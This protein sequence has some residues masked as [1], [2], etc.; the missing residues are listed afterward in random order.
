MFTADLTDLNTDGLVNASNLSLHPGY[1]G[2][3][4]SR[5]IR[6]KGGKTLQDECKRILKQERANQ[7]L[8]ETEVVLTRSH[9]KLK[10]KYILH[11]IA[12]TWTHHIVDN[13]TDQSQS[14]GSSPTTSLSSMTTSVTSSPTSSIS[15]NHVNLGEKFE[16]LIEQT[17]SKILKQA[18]DPKLQLTSMSMPISATSLGGAFDLPVELCAHSLYTQLCDFKVDKST[19]LKTICI[20]SLEPET[21]NTLLEI[22]TNYTEN[23]SES[24]WAIPLSPMTKLLSQTVQEYAALNVE[25]CNDERHNIDEKKS[26]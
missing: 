6:E 12:P 1:V 11:S 14:G 9:G 15:S 2:D 18:H 16:Y 5:R 19:C 3:G 4:I 10:A 20:T 24:S 8:D 7:T 21:V 22:F 13:I 23:Y 17:F 26:K 25:K